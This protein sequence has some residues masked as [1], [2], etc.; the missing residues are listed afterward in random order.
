M[1]VN[2]LTIFLPIFKNFIINAPFGH[3]GGELG[4][5][6][7]RMIRMNEM[8]IFVKNHKLNHLF[9]ISGKA[10]IQGYN[11]AFTAAIPPLTFHF[12]NFKRGHGL[13][14]IGKCGITFFDNFRKC[15]FRLGVKHFFVCAFT[16]FK[17]RGIFNRHMQ[18]ALAK[19][20]RKHTA[21]ANAKHIF[22]AEHGNAVSAHKLRRGGLCR[23]KAFFCR[24]NFRRVL[25][26]ERIDPLCANKTRGGNA[27]LAALLNSQIYV[28]NLFSFKRITDFVIPEEHAAHGSLPL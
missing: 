5:K 20:E 1:F 27:H 24:K 6:S 23:L 3:N 28:F 18:F 22:F 8:A 25:K 15:S 13:A 11:I 16:V 2:K 21:L 19:G 10:R 9:I 26:H 12:A 14:I 17:F 4:I 7:G